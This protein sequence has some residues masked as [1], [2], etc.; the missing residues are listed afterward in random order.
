MEV[1]GPTPGLIYSTS[2]RGSQ[3]DETWI[4]LGTVELGYKNTLYKNTPYKN[5]P[6]I[7]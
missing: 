7:R 1:R 6:A 5:N 2:R 4:G 3:D